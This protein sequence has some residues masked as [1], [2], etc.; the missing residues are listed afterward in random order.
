MY[1][2]YY[3]EKQEVLQYIIQL[4]QESVKYLEEGI[5]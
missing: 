5:N 2:T 4:K 1:L 3:E